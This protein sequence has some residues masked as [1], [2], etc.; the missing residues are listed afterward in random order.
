MDEI[1]RKNLVERGAVEEVVA[2][3]SQRQADPAWAT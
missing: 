3:Q 1:G 2:F